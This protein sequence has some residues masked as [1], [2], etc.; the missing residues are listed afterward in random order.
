M[1]TITEHNQLNEIRLL[2]GPGGRALTYREM[3][4]LI[5]MDHA[6]LYRLLNTPAHKLRL[7]TRTEDRIR[8]FLHQY[9]GRRRRR[10]DDVA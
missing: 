6:Q 3:A 8:E 1:L 7:Y 9:I 2:G 4:T 5:P 10:H